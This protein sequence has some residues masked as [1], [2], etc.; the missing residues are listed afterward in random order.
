VLAAWDLR[1]DV[2]SRG[3]VLWREYWTRLSG[4]GVP[5]TVAY[6]PND[7]V[8]TPRAIDGNDPKVLTALTGAV[9]DLRAK[10][11]ALDVPLGDLQAEPRGSE[12]IPIHGCSEGEGCFNIISTERDAAGRYDPFTGASFVM[13]AAFDTSGVVRGEALLSYSQS[14]NPESEHY[15]DQTR[16]FSQK[17]WLPMR[18]TEQQI[19][20]DPEYER[21]VVT[22]RR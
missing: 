10:G 21:S 8:G 17:Q 4:A 11:I 1:A 22:G 14:E 6:D 7:P 18:F 20:S 3:A 19:R 9:E 15:A 12:R 13:T 5:W 2:G 16:L